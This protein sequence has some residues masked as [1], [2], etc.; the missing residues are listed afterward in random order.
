MEAENP[1]CENIGFQI[2]RE[3]YREVGFENFISIQY[4]AQSLNK[5]KLKSDLYILSIG[6]YILLAEHIYNGIKNM[7]LGEEGGELESRE[8]KNESCSTGKK[9]KLPF[10]ITC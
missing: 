7:Q 4:S 1:M 2:C 8:E 9:K 3:K 5:I 6:S 10:K